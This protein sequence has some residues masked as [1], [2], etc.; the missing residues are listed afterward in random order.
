M[1]IFKAIGIKLDLDFKA[2]TIEWMDYIKIRALFE[3]KSPENEIIFFLK[4]YFDPFNE[5]WGTR[6]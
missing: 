6:K 5:R 2:T 4:N 3:N 1:R